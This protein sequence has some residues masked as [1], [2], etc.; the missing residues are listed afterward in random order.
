MDHDGVGGQVFKA[1]V[2]ATDGSEMANAALPYAKALAREQGCPLVVTHSVEVFAPSRTTGVPMYEREMELGEA[3]V[4]LVTDLK[5]EGLDASLEIVN[6]V[7][8]QPAHVIS[9]VARRVGADLIVV[10]TRGHTALGGLLLGSVTQRLLHVAPCPV[11]A[12]PPVHTR[13][14]EQDGAS[15]TAGV[16]R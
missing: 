14:P 7:A 5:G 6:G 13:A 4:H 12:V 9:D 8:I 2:W 15:E 11:L 1:I 3:L 16:A 10:G